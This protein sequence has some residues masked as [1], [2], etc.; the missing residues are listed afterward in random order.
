[1]RTRTP[2]ILLSAGLLLCSSLVATA[3]V[4]QRSDRTALTAKAM[5][6]R[7]GKQI[8]QSALQING[9]KANLSVFSFEKD[10]A[11]VAGDL[12]TAAGSGLDFSGAMGMA[13]V[14]KDGVVTC[15]LVIALD[16]RNL[17]IVFKIDQSEDEYAASNKPVQQ[18]IKDLP[19]YPGSTPVFF[20]KDENTSTTLGISTADITPTE[21][22]AHYGKSLLAGGWKQLPPTSAAAGMMIY[23]RTDSI[24]CIQ[25]ERSEGSNIC[26]ITVLHKQTK[27]E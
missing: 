20:A 1:M 3:K 13:T 17:T 27:M 6:A 18:E 23:A 22:Y 12:K 15:I 21:A 7:G 19:P 25:A 24:C 2:L 26:R 8:Y 4:F 14:K 5:E 9:G 10:S 11:T 16:P